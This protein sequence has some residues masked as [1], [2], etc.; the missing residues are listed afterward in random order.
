MPGSA[1]GE[2]MIAIGIDMGGTNTKC[3]LINDTGELLIH[4]TM[5][6]TADASPEVVVQKFI[7]L[8][9]ELA[10]EG[11][12]D[13]RELS[14]VGISI[15]AYISE[16]G[17]VTG[18]AHA[19]QDWVGYDLK[20]RLLEDLVAEYYFTLDCPA[21][22]LGEVY[23]GAAK[24]FR[25]IVYVT[26]S[27][28]IG[29][30]IISEGKV[31]TGGLG[32]GGLGHIII[33]ESSDRICEGC[34]NPGCLETFSAKQGILTTTRELLQDNP[35]SMI[36]DLIGGDSGALTPEVVFQ[37]ADSGDEVAREVY[38]RA[39][40]TLGIGLTNII[41]ILAPELVVVGGGIAQAGDLLLE[42]AREA[43][44]KY[45]FPPQLRDVELVQA[46]LG[47]FSGIYGAAAMVFYDLRFSV[48]AC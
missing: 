13:V 30:G 28:G 4:K 5:P 44:R 10:H 36:A 11:G 47:E 21:P 1:E 15:C 27:T 2:D 39:G 31:F 29:A 7:H 16:D 8:I 23:F 42:P 14:G 48:S 38:R 3:G 6:T 22:A 43:I 33:D 12:L 46:E 18:T 9:R 37:A 41:D 45:A 17:V 40:H 32:A 25:D 26:V 19:S 35:E 20:C 34:G 24:G